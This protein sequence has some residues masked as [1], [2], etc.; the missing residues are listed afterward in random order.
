MNP[1]QHRGDVDVA[2]S[3]DQRPRRAL[4]VFGVL[5]LLALAGALHLVGVLPPGA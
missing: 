5:A 1:S 2:D 4:V 3:N